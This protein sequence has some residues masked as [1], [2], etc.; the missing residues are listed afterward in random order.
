MLQKYST[1]FAFFA[2]SVF[3]QHSFLVAPH[4]QKFCNKSRV[5]LLCV[6]LWLKHSLN[7]SSMADEQKLTDAEKVKLLAFYKENNELWVTQGVTRSQKAMKKEELV[8]EFEGKFPIEILE[9][10]FHSLR[11]SFLREYKKYEKDGKV[12][13]K[14][15]TF[16]E[17][18]LFLKEEPKTTRVS[19]TTEE[20]ETFIT[21]YHTNPPLWNH[22]LA[23]YRDLNIR[24]ALIPFIPTSA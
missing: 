19:F 15:W 8:E 18:M 16:Y 20:R 22:G 1:F 9:K 24:R 11:A 17:N 4:V 23:D 14:P 10:A 7:L 3:L 6:M 21:F 13:N 5:F 12:P 2:Q